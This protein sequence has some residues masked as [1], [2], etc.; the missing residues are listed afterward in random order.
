MGARRKAR[1]TAMKVLYSLEFNAQEAETTA[2]LVAQDAELPDEVRGYAATIVA[3]VQ[4]H[5][6]AINETV[7]R[8]SKRW[9]IE[10]MSA[11][12][13]N[14][15]RLA[16]WEILHREDVPVKVAINEAIEIAKK[17]GTQESASFVNG[18][19]DRIA[20]VSGRLTREEREATRLAREE[21]AARAQEEA[22]RA[23][24]EEQE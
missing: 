20:E 2:E 21:A 22:E 4:Q 9:R 14:I 1:E 3:G 18:I 10:R 8:T 11:I 7:A 13:R 24:D 12:D 6:E 23:E 17:F 19:L 5:A 16:T 15:L